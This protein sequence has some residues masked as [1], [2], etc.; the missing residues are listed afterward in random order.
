MLTVRANSLENHD[1]GRKRRYA[2]GEKSC[3]SRHG[4]LIGCIGSQIVRVLYSDESGLGSKA[5]EPIVV[6]AAIMMNMD[7][8]WSKVESELSDVLA[9]TPKNLLHEGRELKGAL[10]YSAVRKKI[11]KASEIL[12]R[13]L[14]VVENCRIPVFYGA[15]DRKGHEDW[16]LHRLAQPKKQATADDDAFD[17]CLTRVDTFAHAEL[18]ADEQILWISDH[19]D[20]KRERRTKFGL[21]WAK[22]LKARNW[23]MTGLSQALGKEPQ[24]LRIADTIYFGHSHESLALQLADV[25]C[26]TI[27]FWLLETLYNWRPCAGRYYEIIRKR[28]MSGDFPPLYYPNNLT[29]NAR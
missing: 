20:K 3:L 19:S 6:V 24:P 4:T 26:S 12:I 21:D 13:T 16:G 15:A 28:V 22:F 14:A 18:A 27:T 23:D 29:Q 2:V 10:L 7:K 17:S 9:D 5:T 1:Y 8:H 25:C 11:R